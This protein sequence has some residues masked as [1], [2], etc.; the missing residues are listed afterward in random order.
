MLK[1]TAGIGVGFLEREGIKTVCDSAM[2]KLGFYNQKAKYFVYAC[3][4]G[5]FCSIGMALAYTFGADFYA[6][7]TLRGA[8]R[9]IIAFA[10]TF[11]LTMII[12]SGAELFTGNVFVMTVSALCGRVKLSRA[13]S[14]LA[15]CYLANIVGA[16][17]F[18]VLIWATG[19][20][21]G[22]TGEFLVNAASVKMTLP[23]WQA[24][25]RGVLCNMLICLGTWSSTKAKSEV[26][27]MVMIFWAVVGFVGSGYEH[28]IAN[29][30]LFTMALLAPHTAQGVSLIGAVNNLVPVTLGNLA[31]GA[32]LVGWAYWF[33]GRGETKPEDS[34]PAA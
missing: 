7:E 15:F 26:A 27:K 4:A 18:G 1:I 21:N 28:S 5:S 10:F 34:L 29:A 22:S 25:F 19:L 2:K 14:L 9:F 32:L 17:A 8:Y 23:F 16:A 12:F 31:G 24:F 11:A 6:S 33:S 3:M 20:L 30:G 13:C